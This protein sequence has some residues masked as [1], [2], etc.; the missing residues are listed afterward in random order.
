[1]QVTHRPG[2]GKQLLVV[3]SSVLI[4]AALAAC[5]G[6]SSSGGGGGNNNPASYG[7]TVTVNGN[8]GSV[9]SNPD[10]GNIHACTNNSCTDSFD[11]NASVTLTATVNTGYTFTGW[12]GDCAGAGTA[13]TAAVT[14]NASRACSAT[15]AANPPLSGPVQPV[16][17]GNRLLDARSGLAWIPHGVNLPGLEYACVGSDNTRPS[18]VPDLARDSLTTAASWGIDVIRL[19]LNQDCWLGADGAPTPG[20]YGNG[21]AAQRAQQ[22]QALVRSWVQA[23]HDAG[24]AVILDL[25]WTAPAGTLAQG[26]QWAMADNQSAAFWSSVAT[27]YKDDPSVMFDLFNEPYSW[28]AHTL[29]WA[30]WRDGGCAMPNASDQDLKNG[31]WDGATTYTVTGMAALVSAVR[32]AGAKQVILLAGL[33]YANTLTSWLAYKP[34]DAQ[35][36]VSWHNYKGQ[37]CSDTACWNSQIAPVAAQVPVVMTEFGYENDDPG[38]FEN[39]MTWADSAGIGYLPWAWW[40]QADTEDDKGN[41]SAYALYTGSA[42]TL[43]PEGTA[44][45][46]RLVKLPN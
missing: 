20:G 1:M 28:D 37:G 10:L 38:Y 35:L 39:A 43:T 13:L 41:V 31:K 44:Y 42:Y 25:H 11:A 12:G 27:A 16:V 46:A 2:L 26:G 24:M 17:A 9:R 22:Y 32:G 40:N 23:A 21:T 34:N 19:P 45:K 14:M 4:G 5:G 6:S 8:G 33:D 15:F 36:A 7:L 18:W 30:C 29:S 3:L